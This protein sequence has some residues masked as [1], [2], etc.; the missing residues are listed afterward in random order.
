VLDSLQK[1]GKQLDFFD[2]IIKYPKVREGE[3]RYLV[4]IVFDLD[5]KKVAIDLRKYQRELARE[6]LF[7]GNTFR[8]AR[9]NVARLTTDNL[10]YLMENLDSEE[11]DGNRWRFVKNNLISN[12]RIQ[13]Q[14]LRQKGLSTSKLEELD[15]ILSEVEESFIKDGGNIAFEKDLER[16]TELYTVCVRKSN[17]LIELAKHEGYRDFLRLVIGMPG[18]VRDGTCH[19]C[20]LIKQ[21]LPDPAFP[22][23]SLLKVW[24][25]DKIGFTAA[26]S[27]TDEARIKSFAICIDCRDE[28]LSGWGYVKQRLTVPVEVFNAYLIP[29]TQGVLT[30]DSLDTLSNKVKNDFSA[31]VSY[32]GYKGLLNFEEALKSFS[33]TMLKESWYML[34]VVF[35]KPESAH[36]RLLSLVQDVPATDLYRLRE[37]VNNISN[38]ACSFFGEAGSLWYLGFSDIY[39]L[40]P[41]RKGR[42]GSNVDW[43]PIVELF[44]S[45]LSFS[46]YP[47]SRLVKYA[48]LLARVY[49]FQ[50]FDIYGNIR[51]PKER[52]LDSEM[53]RAL[54]KFNYFLTMLKNMGVVDNAE[55]EVGEGIPAVEWERD[56]RLKKIGE[57]FKE[58]GYGGLQQ[59]LFL[60]GYLVGEVGRAQYRKG[61]TKKSVLDKVDFNG[62]KTEKVV[63]LSNQILKSLRDYRIL[64]KSNESVYYHAVKL[65]NKHRDWLRVNPVENAFYLLSGY[66]F[67]TYIHLSRGISHD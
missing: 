61:D 34:S 45:I 42:I 56:E 60:L 33:E 20:G 62:M 17:V 6:Y 8:A 44:S 16:G 67:N 13:I 50:L 19:V 57:W 25:K 14:M 51:K 40:L 5:E 24:A 66:A 11:S 49:R 41:L 52:G 30:K 38:S 37:Q 35:G 58:M 1:L 3:E 59:G 36:F 10:K 29:A 9:E 7:V 18:D 15:K 22:S 27:D 2:N 4:R 23:G 65:L 53:C 39:R 47:R 64:D 26:L 28:I 48:T 32:E 55:S 43:R 63:T 46:P 12:T 31:V 54:L 21:V